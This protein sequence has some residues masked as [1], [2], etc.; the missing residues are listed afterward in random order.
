MAFEKDPNELG[1]LWEKTNARGTFMTG[2]IEVNGQKINVVC[3][4]N[5]KGAASHPDWRV[6]KSVPKEAK[7]A[8]PQSDVDADSI[9]F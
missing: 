8:A 9:P 3:F 1:A 7:A 4:P 5:R 2:M 6:L